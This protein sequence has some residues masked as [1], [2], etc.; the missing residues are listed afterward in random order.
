[1][2]K[3]RKK[4]A[5]PCLPCVALLNPG[6]KMTYKQA[7]AAIMDKLDANGWTVKRGLKVPHATNYA[8]DIRL[9]FKS[10]SI[11]VDGRHRPPFSFNASRSTHED[12]KKLAPKSAEEIE[13]ALLWGFRDDNPVAGVPGG[14]VSACIKKMKG[15]HGVYSPGGLCASIAR[16]RGES[17]NRKG[18]PMGTHDI[19]KRELELYIDNDYT[20][21]SGQRQSIEANIQRKVKSGKYDPAKAP[22]L[23]Q[24][25]VDAGA[26]KYVKEFGGSV[27][28]MFP[29]KMREELAKEM[30]ND[31]AEEHGLKKSNP[32]RGKSRSKNPMTKKDFAAMFRSEIMPM[33]RDQEKEWGGGVDG[34]LRR[35]TWNNMVDSYMQDG[36]LPRSA[37]DWAHPSWLEPKRR[38][39]PSKA[40]KTGAK[41]STK[42]VS[43]LL[44]R[45]LK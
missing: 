22:K 4:R 30:S 36:V 19:E 26:K 29:K 11:Y 27:R 37:G 10:Q 20:L 45:A 13:K 15:R 41:K 25:L 18:N 17:I 23:W 35:E 7:Q 28:T 1:M 12:P 40:K 38:R 5:N 34:P 8:G 9:Y 6:K 2:A 24:Y 43:S 21:Y 39:N 14:S 31:Y 44:S 32:K 3:A 42:S 33:V 16:K